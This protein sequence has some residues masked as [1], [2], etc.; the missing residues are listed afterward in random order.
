MTSSES[1]SRPLVLRRVVISG[2][3]VF[4]HGVVQLA[5]RGGHLDG[6][7][8]DVAGGDRVLEESFLVIMPEQLA[9]V[10]RHP[11]ANRAEPAEDLK[12]SVSRRRVQSLEWYAALPVAKR[13][14]D[15]LTRQGGGLGDNLADQFLIDRPEG[16]LDILEHRGQKLQLRLAGVAR[17]EL[18]VTNE[19][20]LAGRPPR[21]ESE[22]IEQVPD[23]HRVNLHGGRGQEDERPGF[24]LQVLHESK[25]PVRAAFLRRP[26]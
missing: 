25:Q 15:S 7:V 20:V 14:Q 10:S 6:D 3:D 24:F 4:P 17:R 1:D 26:R 13:L 9:G 22:Q 19:I 8:A 5:F 23:L 11:A 18:K 12:S 2:A 16:C 21:R